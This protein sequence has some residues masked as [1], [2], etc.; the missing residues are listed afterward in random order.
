[1]IPHTVTNESVT[2]VLD[3]KPYT[4]RNG[5]PKF[6]EAREAVFRRDW[7]T[8]RHLASPGSA[9]EHWLQ[10][11]FALDDGHLTYKGKRIDPALNTRIREMAAQGANPTGWM[12]FWTRLQQNPSYRSVTQ[13]YSFLA[14]EAIPIDEDTGEILAYKSVTREYKDHHTGKFDNSPGVTL[15]MPRNEIS[16]DP[17]LAC[18]VGFHVG[19]LSYAQTFGEGKRI[20][21]V[22]IDPADVVCV[23]YDS[24]ARKMRVCR[25]RV[26]GN[27]SG[28]PMPNTSTRE[29][30]DESPVEDEGSIDSEPS[31]TDSEPADSEPDAPDYDALHAMGAKAL[32]DVAL[33]VLR[34]Y[35]RHALKIFGASKIPGG[36]QAL[37]KRILEVRRK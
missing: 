19:A 15:E 30:D 22:A 12:K 28:T 25:Y 1:M 17:N 4:V 27:Y 14:H 3:G 8:I 9:I 13:L 11:E 36:K 16:D 29:D 7:E 21:I 24:S 31:A 23:P 5:S 10:G 37:I 2:V 6:E 18:H 33:S 20:V 26:R 34:K 35:A 32:Q